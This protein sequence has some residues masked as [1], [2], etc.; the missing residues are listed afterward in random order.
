[1]SSEISSN[2]KPINPNQSIEIQKQ[3]EPTIKKAGGTTGKV[4]DLINL[5]SKKIQE[6]EPRSQTTTSFHGNLK[7]ADKTDK[8]TDGVIQDVLDPDFKELK[9][10]VAAETSHWE[11]FEEKMEGTRNHTT[12]NYEKDLPFLNEPSEAEEY[13]TMQKLPDEFEHIPEKTA[14]QQNDKSRSSTM[15]GVQ[16]ST[17]DLEIGEEEELSDAIIKFDEP[18]IQEK[19]GSQEKIEKADTKKDIPIQVPKETKKIINE[20]VVTKDNQ[21][22]TFAEH[23]KELTSDESKNLKKL[24]EKEGKIEVKERSMQFLKK[25]FGNFFASGQKPE[26]KKALQTILTAIQSEIKQGHTLYIDAH[27][28]VQSLQQLNDDFLKTNYAQNVIKHS[29]EI[30]E[31]CLRSLGADIELKSLDRPYDG[32]VT[33]NFINILLKDSESEKFKNNDLINERLSFIEQNDQEKYKALQSKYESLKSHFHPM[34]AQKFVDSLKNDYYSTKF[35]TNKE[36]AVWLNIL[37]DLNQN[38]WQSLNNKIDLFTAQKDFDPK[39]AQDFILS[40]EKTVRQERIAHSRIEHTSF[41]TA[42]LPANFAINQKELEEIPIAMTNSLKKLLLRANEINNKHH[43]IDEEIKGPVDELL[44]HFQSFR[45]QNW[46]NDEEYKQISEAI[47]EH[48][49]L[50]TKN[51]ETSKMRIMNKNINEIGNTEKTF[52]TG[53]IDLKTLLE[54]LKVPPDEYKELSDIIKFG[55]IIMVKIGKAE[56]K[57]MA[58]KIKTV[59]DVYSPTNEDMK[60]YCEA[61]LGLIPKFEALTQKVQNIENTREGKRLSDEFSSEHGGADTSSYLITFVQRLPRHE[62]LLREINKNIPIEQD[63]HV[64][65]AL[66][67]NQSYISDFGALINRSMPKQK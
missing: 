36:V 2:H 13:D 7:Q 22:A 50:E 54:K 33:L 45:D 24:T 5:W 31:L 6:N 12:T 3:H 52:L 49:K 57:S 27:G 46:I 8:K 59:H 67:Q 39:V 30:A 14:T 20:K 16:Q 1:M 55:T 62:L 61:F 48:K 26:T 4:R 53:L 9:Q 11:N 29:E 28:D 15:V 19:A 17:Q 64:H 60:N 34:E 38:K 32:E 56:E 47:A 18:T 43:F 40:L 21:F 65:Q 41:E 51:K 63:S 23:L 42:D 37:K 35:K 10:D 44:A 25:I 58:D 66:V